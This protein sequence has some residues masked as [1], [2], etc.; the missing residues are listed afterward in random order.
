M[1]C[2]NSHLMQCSSVGD[3]SENR[4]SWGVYGMC[5]YGK[6]DGCRLHKQHQ[7]LCSQMGLKHYVF[8]WQVF[9]LASWLVLVL[10]GASKMV[11]V[12]KKE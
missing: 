11:S 6:W 10:G 5:I 8:F 3:G 9:M 2:P 7:G 1:G 4:S 12:L